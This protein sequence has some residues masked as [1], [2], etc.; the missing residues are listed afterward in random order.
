MSPHANP[1]PQLHRLLLALLLELLALLALPVHAA[2]PQ[3]GDVLERNIEVQSVLRRIPLPPGKWKVEVAKES[4]ETLSDGRKVP[5]YGL[6]LANA[7]P[8]ADIVLL[9]LQF[10]LDAKAN[11]SSQPCEGAKDRPHL[12][13]N[14]FGSQGNSVTVLCSTVTVLNSLRGTLRAAPK[15]RDAWTKLHLAPLAARAEEFPEQV[16]Q[17]FGYVSAGKS[18][19]VSLLAYA[20]PA[21]YRLERQGPGG[22]TFD[23]GSIGDAPS[24]VGAKYYAVTLAAWLD[25]YLGQID[26]YYMPGN[27]LFG[28]AR[29]PELEFKLLERTGPGDV[30]VAA[31][32]PA[33]PEPSQRV[34]AP[35]GTPP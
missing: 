6:T 10:T 27:N 9:T 16:L 5:V 33:A 34:V 30:A 32:N 26:R 35:A 18:D 2:I 19:K 14:D 15:A 8:G 22:L 11:W 24:G 31:T 23:S 7:D 20:N 13:V 21:V 25:G 3:A 17:L 28:R 12:A 29:A 1:S 4:A